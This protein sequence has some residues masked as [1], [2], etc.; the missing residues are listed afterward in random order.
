MIL[1]F[2]VLFSDILQKT[3]CRKDNKCYILALEGGGDKGA[4]Q[5]GAISGLIANLPTNMTQYDVVTGISVGALNAAGFSI[6]EVGKEKEAS[7]FL[8]DKWRTLKGKKSIFKNW[9]LGPLYGLLF[10]TGLYDTSPL[11]DFLESLISYQEVKRKIVVGSTN[12]E[13]GTY[14]TWDEEN[15][16]GNFES[17]IEAV[18]ASSAF[19]VIFP[20]IKK[21]NINWVDGG[22]KASIDFASGINKCLDIG[23][24]LENIFIDAVLCSSAARLPQIDVE[25]LHPV[26]V[27]IRVL[28]I[29]GYD[30]SMKEI[31][32][33]SIDFPKTNFRYIVSPSKKLPSSLIPLTFSPKQIEE[34][35]EIGVEDAKNA[36]IHGF[37]GNGKEIIEN[38]RKER[39][40]RIR[41]K[42]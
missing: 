6:F 26:E 2:L 14:H 24:S 15:F 17:F 8:L 27:L 32:D 39:R 19:P 40:N 36:I 34:M 18:M 35:I 3:K 33:I 28:E 21:D 11:Y 30:Y 29:Y 10:K 13:N 1:F 16:K 38:Y 22:V 31:D 37:E 12:I 20:M 9:F 7:D 4:Y 23:Y 41:V 5:A 25:Q 42:N